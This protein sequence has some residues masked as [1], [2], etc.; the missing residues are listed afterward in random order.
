MVWLPL[1]RFTAGVMLHTP[2]A[3]AVAAPIWLAPSNNTTA[4]PASVTPVN[5]GRAIL[6]IASLLDEPVSD[7]G[8]MASEAG[9]GAVS[10]VT[11]R[12][13][14]TPAFPAR[15]TTRAA[16]VQLALWL[17]ASMTDHAVPST[18]GATQLEP[19]SKLICSVSS[20]ASG[21]DNVP[22]TVR[23]AEPLL[24]MKSPATRLSAVIAT[25]VTASAGGI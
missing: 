8:A 23:P 11:A 10:S 9:G 19:P 12:V 2:S 6:V 16:M 15:S 1:A 4:L 7:T 24:V 25:I 22:N 3:P 20:V 5:T 18:V 17:P 14:S 13:A 21:A